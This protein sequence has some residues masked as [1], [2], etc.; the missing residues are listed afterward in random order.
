MVITVIACTK[1]DE[2]ELTNE[3][4]N[5]ESEDS[6]RFD[7]KDG[8]LH[9]RNQECLEL[10]MLETH[11]KTQ[12]ELKA[13][14]DSVGGNAFWSLYNEVFDVY[15]V[16]DQYVDS[17]EEFISAFNQFMEEYDGVVYR[18]QEYSDG[19]LD[20]GIMP[21]IGSLYGSVANENGIYA[22]GDEFFD[23]K[24]RVSTR[25]YDKN[26]ASCYKYKNESKCKDDRKMWLTINNIGTSS[27]PNYYSVEVYHEIRNRWCNWK[28]YETD[29]YFTTGD[30]FINKAT[31]RD[32]KA[33]A[34]IIFKNL[35]GNI[36]PYQ[37][38]FPYVQIYNRGVGESNVC[39]FGTY[40]IS[41]PED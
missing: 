11:G 12:E 2:F 32:T 19:E 3:L 33:G 16:L 23:A 36:F 8:G 26:N 1:Q 24:Y 7:V 27:N 13:W 25:S 38:S 39:E 18:P 9:F 17:Q 14:G 34:V 4:V 41:P 30:N 5:I 22:I 29:Y 20:F 40:S 37:F 6:A 31:A 35:D 15:D 28:T 10:T 21:L